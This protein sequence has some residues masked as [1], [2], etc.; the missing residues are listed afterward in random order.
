MRLV[1]DVSRTL[2][3]W[4]V[5]AVMNSGKEAMGRSAQ[6][7]GYGDRSQHRRWMVLDVL[8]R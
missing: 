6:I 2:P 8:H 7:R 3:G 5:D 1:L 4:D